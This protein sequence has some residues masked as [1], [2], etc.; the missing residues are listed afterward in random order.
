MSEPFTNIFF[1]LESICPSSEQLPAVFCY[2]GKKLNAK[3]IGG[4]CSSL[5]EASPIISLSGYNAKN[6]IAPEIFQSFNPLFIVALTFPV[7][8]VFAWLNKKN[9]TLH[10]EEDRYRDDHRRRWIPG[11]PGCF[12]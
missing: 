1:N 4:A 10:P 8:G 11:H 7:M 9:R 6:P 5:A 12:H 3:L 2:S